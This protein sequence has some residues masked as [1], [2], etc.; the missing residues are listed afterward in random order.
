MA[1]SYDPKSFWNARFGR[2]G[3]TGEV[4][5]LLY[6]YDQG[7][8][9]RAIDKILSR[10]H[11]TINSSTEILDVGCGTGD[12]IWS[13]RKYGGPTTTGIDVSDET[14]DYA[15]RR[16]A[17]SANVRLHTIGVED[18]DFPSNSFDLVTCI[19][20][21]QHI[22]DDRKYV[23]A[24][25]NI[26]KASRMRGHILTMDFC[27]IKVKNKKPA[28]YLVIR[29]RDQYVNI[30]HNNGCTLICEFGLPRIGVR[31]YRAL[32][33]IVARLRRTSVSHTGRISEDTKRDP[34][35]RTIRS[36]IF[37]LTKVILLRLTKPLDDYLPSFPGRFTDMRI[38]IFRKTTYSRI[39][40]KVPYESHA[41]LKLQHSTQ[42][43][44]FH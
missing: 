4:D 21:L 34:Y 5:K 30:F 19:N 38:L 22:T 14:I 6:T 16:F 9:L 24:V 10:A 42:S 18:M 28:P 23:R 2:Y 32:C 43:N 7:Q 3:H 8:R 37:H 44:I 40:G 17:G 1:T 20:I 13:F 26:T 31:L 12:L 15:R 33:W 27:P 11:I 25:E 35:K 41:G 29:S 39:S 36:R